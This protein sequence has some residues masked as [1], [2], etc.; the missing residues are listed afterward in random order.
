MDPLP[1]IESAEEPY[2]VPRIP[3]VDSQRSYAG[4]RVSRNRLTFNVLILTAAMSMRDE[5]RSK[6][7]II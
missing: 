2:S 6:A 1:I 3:E 4:T 7:P 5:T